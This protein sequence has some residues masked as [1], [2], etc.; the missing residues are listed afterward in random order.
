MARQIKATFVDLQDLPLPNAPVVVTPAPAVVRV[1]D[2]K[3]IVPV[4]V[5]FTTDATGAITGPLI[6]GLYETKIETASRVPAYR[7]TSPGDLFR[8]FAPPVYTPVIAGFVINPEFGETAQNGETLT[9][10]VSGL[11]GGEA[12]VHAWLADGNP[13]PGATAPT[14]TPQ[15]GINIVDGVP[16]VYAPTINGVLAVTLPTIVR[17][18]PPRALSNPAS[19]S[20]VIGTGSQ[21][22]STALAFEGEAL[23]Y[24]A[25]NAAISPTT[26]VVV[27]ATTV[28]TSL[29]VSVTASNSGGSATIA[30]GVDVVVVAPPPP[31]GPITPGLGTLTINSLPAFPVL[32]IVPGIGSLTF[33]EASVVTPDALQSLQALRTSPTLTGAQIPLSEMKT[34]GVQPAPAGVTFNT[35]AKTIA[36]AS[37]ADIELIGWDL[38]GYAGAAVSAG[39]GRGRIRRLRDCRIGFPPGATASPSFLFDNYGTMIVENNDVIGPF[40]GL[41]FGLVIFPRAGS[42]QIIRR[43]RTRGNKSDLFKMVN[44]E[45]TGNYCDPPVT[46]PGGLTVYNAATVYPAGAWVVQSSLTSAFFWECLIPGTVG[47]PPQFSPRAS[48]PAWRYR[49]PHADQMTVPEVLESPLLIEGN[50]INFNPFD[51]AYPTPTGDAV[52]NGL[53]NAIRLGGNRTVAAP[54]ISQLVSIRRNLIVYGPRAGAVFQITG[55]DANTYEPVLFEDNWIEAGT[56]G[57]PLYQDNTRP[58][59]VRWTNNR[60]LDG[61]LYDPALLG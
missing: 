38:M 26:G 47:V 60:R 7:S 37:D 41:G 1:L 3:A 32:T 44:G 9:G 2:G 61:T 13:I 14:F 56:N 34:P 22:V 29:V 57:R 16:L 58:N 25:V 11:A 36:F 53:N 33:Q 27:V 40:N 49:N 46:T 8:P 4:P 31:I 39:S 6:D 55:Q 45:F 42:T 5:S 21:T 12:V 15:I 48:T 30:F 51:R 18:V 35:A 28:T 54:A 43:N 59:N 17:H 50:Y 52:E 24:T 19:V 23:L 10:S 20:F